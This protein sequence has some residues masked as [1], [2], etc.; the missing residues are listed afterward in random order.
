MAT[1]MPAAKGLVPGDQS[2]GPDE[3]ERN[4]NIPVSCI[5][6]FIHMTCFFF[7]FENLVRCQFSV[8]FVFPE[9]ENKF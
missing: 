2:I 5:L 9:N 4:S 6:E 8:N 7:G 3:G 1:A